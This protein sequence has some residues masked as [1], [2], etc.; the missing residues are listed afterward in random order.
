MFEIADS[1]FKV[2]P[3]NSSSSPGNLKV[4]YNRHRSKYPNNAQP[5]PN[6][7]IELTHIPLHI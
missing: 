5:Q 7:M 3:F 6:R 4:T 1:W 2:D